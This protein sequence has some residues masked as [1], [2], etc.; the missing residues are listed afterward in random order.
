MPEPINSPDHLLEDHIHQP[1]PIEHNENGLTVSKKKNH[2]PKI[3]IAILLLIVASMVGV[4]YWYNHQL[5]A[6]GGDKNQM[7]KVTIDKNS[8]STK[9]AEMLQEKNIIHNAIAFN[10]YLRL[11]DNTSKLQAGTYRLSPSETVSQ[12]VKH[13]TDGSIDQFSITFLPGATLAESKEVFKKAGYSDQE[14]SEGLNAKYTSPL[15]AGKPASADLE[16]YIYGET[17]KFNTGATVGE[18]LTRVFEEYYSNIEKNNLI[19]GFQKNGLNL[20]Q[21]ITLASIIQREV[22][23]PSDRK[24]VAQVFYLRLKQ[25]MMLGSD[26]TY[27]YIADKTGVARNVNID[28]PYNTR[29]YKGL[30]PGPIST[31][32]LTALQAVASPASGDYL[33]FLS[34]D[35]D[36]TYFARTNEEHEANI[37]NHCKVKC[38][39][40]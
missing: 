30:P 10:V 3:I 36:V 4:Y 35:D 23:S 27:Q 11:S 1:L 32:G 9:I 26:V 21:G 37:V 12:I 2:A 38:S 33:Y 29:K 39:V 6:V 18:I 34:G 16:G 25:D 40:Q 19:A 14:I 13:L 20:Y 8:T 5:S 17:Y 7:I 22:S 28:S 15:F 31:P 24:Q